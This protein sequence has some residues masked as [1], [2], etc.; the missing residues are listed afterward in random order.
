MFSFE[1]RN[2]RLQLMIDRPKLLDQPIKNDQITYDSIQKIV[3][4]Q[5]VDYTTGCFLNHSYFKENYKLI[6]INLIL[7]QKQSS[8]L[9]L[10]EI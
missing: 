2:K 7:I 1:S 10:V 9:A 6:V 8:K 3:A 4:C 5:E